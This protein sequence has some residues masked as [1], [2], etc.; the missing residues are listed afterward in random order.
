[1]FIKDNIIY[2]TFKKGSKTYFYSSLFFPIAVKSRVFVLYAFV[3][4]ADNFVDS[5]PQNVTGFYKF[6]KDYYDALK[7]G[8]ANDIVVDSFVELKNELT[9]KDEWIDAFFKSMEMD[10]EKKVYKDL[11]ETIE[12]I[13]GSAEVIGMMMCRIMGIDPKGYY[14]AKN[15]GKAMQYINFIRDIKDDNLLGRIYLPV[16]IFKKYGLD[17]LDFNEVKE[18]EKGFKDFL[19]DE[20]KRYFNWQALAEKG[21]RYIPKYLLVPVKTASDMYKYTAKIIFDDPLIVYKIKVKPRIRRIIYT[22]LKN[23]ADTF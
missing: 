4:K 17:S 16:N 23:F 22:S 11:D 3:R 6:K 5:I 9:I 1:M 12:Y 18:N 2:D 10:L 13:Y 14:Y 20:L 21:Y 15:L 7:T 8:K 19:R